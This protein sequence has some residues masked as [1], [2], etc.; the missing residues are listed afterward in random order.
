MTPPTVEPL[1]VTEQLPPDGVHDDAE[2]VT[3]PEPLCDQLTVPVGLEPVT[4]AVHVLDEPNATLEGTQFTVIVT[5]AVW[6]FAVS[7]I[8]PFII[9]NDGLFVP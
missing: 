9:T 2:N 7:V 5:F 1:A 4:V 8:G 3:L 6:K